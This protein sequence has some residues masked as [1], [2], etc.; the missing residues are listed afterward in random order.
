MVTISSV[1]VALGILVS[2]LVFRSVGSVKREL[3]GGQRQAAGSGRDQTWG[4]GEDGGVDG[5][6]GNEKSKS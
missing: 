3:A 5:E 4:G 1:S 2:A 6:T